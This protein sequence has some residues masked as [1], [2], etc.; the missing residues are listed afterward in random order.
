MVRKPYH[1][2]DDREGGV[3]RYYGSNG[4][5]KTIAEFNG[6]CEVVRCFDNE[7]LY[8]ISARWILDPVG[9]IAQGGMPDLFLWNPKVSKSMCV[10]VKSTE[11]PDPK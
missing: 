9:T 5:K 1:S 6:T 10:E 8:K 3:Y 2:L 7:Q 11:R 4:A